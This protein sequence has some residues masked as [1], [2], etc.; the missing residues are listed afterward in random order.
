MVWTG[1]WKI[2]PFIPLPW[3]NSKNPGNFGFP[4]RQASED[5]NN[6]NKTTSGW[7]FGTWIL[8]SIHWEIHHPNW[9]SHI[10]QRGRY[11]TNQTC[12]FWGFSVDMLKPSCWISGCP[13]LP[14]CLG[15]GDSVFLV[16]FLV[17]PL[18]ICCV[19]CST[20]WRCFG[21]FPW[22]LWLHRIVFS[23]V[24]SP[25]DVDILQF[26]QDSTNWDI[27]ATR[28]IQIPTILPPWHIAK[29]Y[30]FWRAPADLGVKKQHVLLYLWCIFTCGC[31]S[32]WGCA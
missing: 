23:H 4:T 28:M 26:W 21:R 13:G 11:T 17:A 16:R 7:W 8:F 20:D 5:T 15:R 14:S 2:V 18:E 9:R 32:K 12:F 27:L 29:T 30:R 31:V 19:S 6:R 10:F 25:F 24:S 1:S 3:C 22:V